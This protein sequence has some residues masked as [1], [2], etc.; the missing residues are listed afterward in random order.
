VTPPPATPIAQ[1]AGA[2]SGQIGVRSASF[3]SSPWG[4]G[5]ADDSCLLHSGATREGASDSLAADLTQSGKQVQGTLRF[6]SG[7]A[8]AVAGS[9][10]GP[11]L[12]FRLTMQN[13]GLVVR[14]ADGSRY[15][16]SA[17]RA[18][19]SLRV[20]DGASPALNGTQHLEYR[21]LFDH[22]LQFAGWLHLDLD[23]SARR[24]VPPSP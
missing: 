3:E 8:F 13:P 22:D 24:Q 6:G 2:W 19:A 16:L 5:F 1:V 21:V 12:T 11:E 4:Y 17:E 14:C 10:A 15:R 20:E 7:P 18:S 9:I 23:V